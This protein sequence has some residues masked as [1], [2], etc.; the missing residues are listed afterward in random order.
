[1]SD[2]GQIM[3]DLTGV[4]ATSDTTLSFQI[5]GSQFTFGPQQGLSFAGIFG[6]TGIVVSSM[7]VQLAVSAGTTLGGILTLYGV[8]GGAGVALTTNA[9]DFSTSSSKSFDVQ[10]STNS[11]GV[12]EGNLISGMLALG[13]FGPE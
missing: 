9:A 2:Y 3:I 7:N 13:D 11:S 5:H 1:M 12:R 6:V 8:T 10:W 4:T